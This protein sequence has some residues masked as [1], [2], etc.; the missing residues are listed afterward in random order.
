MW[1]IAC[2]NETKKGS[3]MQTKNSIAEQLKAVGTMVDMAVYRQINSLFI[4]GI[5]GVGKTSLVIDRFSAANMTEGKDYLLVK[6]VTRPMGLYT[7]LCENKDSTIVFDDCDTAWDDQDSANILKAALEMARVRK[8]A[9]YSQSVKN[10]GLP[11][12]FNFTGSVIFVSNLDEDKVDPAIRSRSYSYGVFADN[13]QMIEFME[14]MLEKVE[15]DI[16]IESK[17]EVFEY[18]KSI[19]NQLRSFDLRTLV[20]TIRLKVCKGGWKELALQFV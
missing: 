3:L 1:Y 19:S 10:T 8:V 9:Y 5:P 14:Q 13:D 20:K 7:I 11:M 4:F 16:S 18:L 2:M 15:P 17:R 12:S 6:G